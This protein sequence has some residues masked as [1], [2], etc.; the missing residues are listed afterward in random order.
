MWFLSIIFL[1]I[2]FILSALSF[3]KN[4]YPPLLLCSVLHIST[5]PIFFIFCSSLF[6]HKRFVQTCPPLSHFDFVG[7]I[8]FLTVL[9]EYFNFAFVL[10]ASFWSS[11]ISSYLLYNFCS[12]FH[13][14]IFHPILLPSQTGLVFLLCSILITSFGSW[15]RAFSDVL[16]TL[17]WVEISLG[18]L[19]FAVCTAIFPHSHPSS[20]NGFL[21]RTTSVRMPCTTVN[22]R[23]LSVHLLPE[24]FNICLLW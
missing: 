9:N 21:M 14:F 17:F 23:L 24:N 19:K 16:F 13:H 6:H 8:L 10:L 12:S 20:H 1:L 4:N 11:F 15:I 18:K 2:T 7:S 5:V 22:N 3:I